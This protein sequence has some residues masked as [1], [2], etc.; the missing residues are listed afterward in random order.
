[1]LATKIELSRQEAAKDLHL[2]TN[3]AANN[4]SSTGRLLLTLV[5]FWQFTQLNDLIASRYIKATEAKAY[6]D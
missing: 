2:L 1:M 3:Y 6:T 4:V 5:V